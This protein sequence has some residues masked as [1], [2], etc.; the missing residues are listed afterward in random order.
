VRRLGRLTGA[1]T[2]KKIEGLTTIVAKLAGK[3]GNLAALRASAQGGL[4]F[5]LQ[6]EKKENNSQGFTWEMGP[7]PNA[8]PLRKISLFVAR[9]IGG[10][11][12]FTKNGTGPNTGE[13]GACRSPPPS[14]QTPPPPRPPPEFPP[15]LKSPPQK[16]RRLLFGGCAGGKQKNKK[17]VALLCPPILKT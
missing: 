14:S 4:L 7:K 2:P 1:K 6:E 9:G 3:S 10:Q 17:T 5:L 16:N 8:E 15:L 11:K 13:P 12:S